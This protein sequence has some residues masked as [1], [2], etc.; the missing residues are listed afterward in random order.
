MGDMKHRV[1]IVEDEM[2]ARDK[3]T[4]YILSREEL[5]LAGSA[6]C[7]K[8]ALEKLAAGGFDLLFLDINLP[9]ISGLDVLGSLEDPPHVIF[10]TAY[11]EFAVKAFELGALD[12]LLKPFTRERFNAAVDRFLAAAQRGSSQRER[13]LDAGLPVREGGRHHIIPFGEILYFT[14]HGKHTVVHTAHRD[15]ETPVLLGDIEEK[16]AGGPFLRVHRQH[17]VNVRHIASLRYHLGGRYIVTLRDEDDT[18]LPVGRA[19][20]GPLKKALDMPE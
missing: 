9:D 15:F 12:Y 7:G 3:L 6:K 16:L 20:A 19:F 18:E 8:E 5:A 4:D 13:L 11:D 2:P 14:S 17:I 1:F 10:T